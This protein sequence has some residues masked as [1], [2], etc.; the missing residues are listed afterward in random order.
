MK[1]PNFYAAAGLDRAGWRR[2]D[3][4]WIAERLADPMSRFVPIWRSQNLVLSIDG[5]APQAAFLT[6][7]EILL[8]GETALLGIVEDSAYFAL[9]LSHVET[10]LDALKVA[11]PLLRN[12]L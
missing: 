8:E 6:R 5:A 9:D 4:A 7:H 11:M 10:P 3:A 12:C 2:K 1:E